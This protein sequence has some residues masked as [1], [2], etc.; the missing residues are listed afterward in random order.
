MHKHL[1]L[2]FSIIL[3]ILGISVFYV[4]G[5]VSANPD[6]Q[7][8]YYTPTAQPDGRIVY[9]VKEGDSCISIA[10]LNN[11]SEDQLRLLNDL[12]GDACLFLRIGRELVLGTVEP[13]TGPPPEMTA[14]PIFP[15]P[16]PFNG[17]ADLCVLLFEDINGNTLID[18]DTIELPLEGGAV[19]VNDRVGKVS[20]SEE[21][22]N[23]EEICFVGLDEGEY[24]VSVAVPSG[25]N[26]TMRNS[27]TLK[28]SA[29]DTVR[30][31][32]GAQLSSAGEVEIE[33]NPQTSRSPFLGIMGGLI[34]VV[35]LG[36]GLYAIRI[37]RR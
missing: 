4:A 36:F 16:I 31:D 30:I 14:T 11:I 23:L 13:D 27:A 15:S 9:T 32:F 28:L 20:L 35:G 33:D 25:Y 29:G 3:T 26:P 6:L 18:D 24:T 7:V 8:F 22:N 2:I 12:D 5:S 34:L 10:L 1:F 37:Q 21:T 19:S 17:T